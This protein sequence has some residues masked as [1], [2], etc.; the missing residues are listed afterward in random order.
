MTEKSNRK[1]RKTEKKYLRMKPKKI[2]LKM[3]KN[4]Q[5]QV[6]LLNPSESPKPA[7]H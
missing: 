1:Q 7:I 5:I 3:E 6:N 4:K 2:S